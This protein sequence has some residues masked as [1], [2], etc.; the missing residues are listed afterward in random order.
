MQYEHQD[1]KRENHCDYLDEGG[2]DGAHLPGNGHVQEYAE[3][4]EWQ[5]WYDGI[6][7][8]LHHN[9]AELVEE[10][11]DEVSGSQESGSKPDDE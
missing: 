10:L 4:V 9:G 2:E 3:Y 11:F 6:F 7:N 5:Q 8:D 1:V